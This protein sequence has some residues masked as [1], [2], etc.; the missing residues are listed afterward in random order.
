MIFASFTIAGL[1]Y[2]LTYRSHVAVRQPGAW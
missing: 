2:P 1:A